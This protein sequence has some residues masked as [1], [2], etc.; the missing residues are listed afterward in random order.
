VASYS[1]TNFRQN[2]GGRGTYRVKAV[3]GRK[4]RLLLLVKQRESE[5]NAWNNAALDLVSA[6]LR[7]QLQFFVFTCMSI[8]HFLGWFDFSAFGCVYNPLQVLLKLQNKMRL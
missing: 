6:S 3:R 5:L 7:V 1:V 2:F 8:W 4:Y